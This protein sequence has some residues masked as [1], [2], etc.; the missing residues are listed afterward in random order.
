MKAFRKLVSCGLILIYL[1]I[2][3]GAV[4]RMTGSGMGCPDW[5]KC[6]GYYIPPTQLKQ[7]QWKP[8]HSYQKGAFIVHQNQLFKANNNL[9]SQDN[10]NPNQW[11]KYTKHNYSNFNA[12]HT[13]IEYINRLVTVLS[14][15]PIL[16]MFI[17]S[18]FFYKKDKR[19]AW[20]SLSVVIAMLIQAILGKLVVDTNL[21]P[22]RITVHMFVAFVIVAQM[23]YLRYIAVEDISNNKIFIPKNN[24]LKLLVATV[25]GLTLIQVVLGTQVR[26]FVDY[27]IK[28][29]GEN[30]NASQWLAHPT[31]TFYVHRSFSILIFIVNILLWIKAKSLN[32]INHILIKS[33]IVLIV[34]E[35][36]TGILMYYFDFP[37][38]SQPLHLV[39]AS[40]LFGSQFLLLIKISHNKDPR[41]LI[42]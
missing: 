33:N 41:A 20:V 8:K 7:V 22:W 36:L 38:L 6:F 10:F 15:I 17:C 2:I 23:I 42:N 4:V 27:Q 19:I 18:W 24:N 1:I 32:I 29:L 5:P 26:Q 40:L 25:V 13:W 35:I 14:G 12:L 3:A 30:G 11:S 21:L 34:M 31:I 37:F 16:I 28:S 39:L 9:T